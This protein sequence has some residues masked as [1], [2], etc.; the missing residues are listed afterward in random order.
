MIGLGSFA[1]LAL[2]SRILSPANIVQ[3]IDT[4]WFNLASGLTGDGITLPLCD[5][6]PSASTSLAGCLVLVPAG[7]EELYVLVGSL[8]MI[9][10]FQNRGAAAVIVY[11]SLPLIPG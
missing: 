1:C 4:P 6:D 5:A 8:N 10:D 7:S 3:T 11:E 9:L 2:A